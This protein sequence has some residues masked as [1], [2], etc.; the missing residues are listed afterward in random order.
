MSCEKG[1]LNKIIY[2][3]GCTDESACN[4]EPDASKD[5]ESCEYP[6]E[7]FDC[8]DEC[9]V[10]IDCEGV[11]NGTSLEDNCGVCD[12]DAENDC[13]EDCNGVWG[14]SA[15]ED[16]TGTCGGTTVEDCAG[17]CDGNALE[18]MCGT[19]D[20]NFENDCIQDCAGVWGGTNWESDCGCVSIYNFGDDCDDCLGEPYGDA[21]LDCAGE[22]DGNALEDM[23]GT[24]DN[25]FENDCIQDCAGVWGGTTVEDCS[26]ECDG[27]AL[28]DMCGTCDSNPNNNCCIDIDGNEYETVQIGN[29]EWM[30]ENLKVT[31]YQ[32]GDAIFHFPDNEDWGLLIQGAYVNYNNN[33]TNSNTYGRLYNWYA[34][35]DYR[36]VCPEGFHIPSDEEFTVLTDFL[37][38]ESVAGGKMKETGLEHWN[39]P[40]TGATNESGFTALPAGYRY[41]HDGTFTN[42]GI[43]GTFW[44][45]TVSG[46][47]EA[48]NRDIE[49]NSSAVVRYSGGWAFGLS[50]RCLRDN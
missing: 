38:G 28:E 27:N 29:Q 26:G 11:C 9:I 48:Y 20:N 25:N 36:G 22:C 15:S 12:T 43:I 41:Y 2:P 35:D 13:E 14:G 3:P 6:I 42:M 24:C 23:C 32:N 30:S 17:E 44:T 31:H 10:T 5:D 50:I 16:C 46:W 7:F 1:W 45:S 33:P 49:Y 47:A 21:T 4:Y 40:N 34:V 8:E 18:D 19:C 39:S 37:G